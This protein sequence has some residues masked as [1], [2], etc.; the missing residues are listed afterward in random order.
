MYIPVTPCSRCK[1]VTF[2]CT[3]VCYSYCGNTLFCQDLLSFLQKSTSVRVLPVR[4]EP[5]VTT[6]STHTAAHALLALPEITV[7]QVRNMF[8]GFSPVNFKQKYK[9]EIISE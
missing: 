7:R 4:T 1:G 8:K 6:S 5:L 2:T 3:Q 9:T